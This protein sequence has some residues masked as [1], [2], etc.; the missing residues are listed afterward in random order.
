MK[1]IIDISVIRLM[2]IGCFLFIVSGCEREFSDDVDFA[3]FTPN[4]DVFLDNFSPGLDYFPFV[5]AGADPEAFSVVSDETFSGNGA[6]RFD[7]PAFGNGFVGAT[8]NTTV[9]RDLSSFDALTFYAKASKSATIN[10]IGYGL[11]G[12]TANKFRVALSG[13]AVSTR[14]EKYTIP[15]PDSSKLIDQTGLFWLAEGASFE[16][17]EG[18]YILWFDEVKF[19]KLGTV[20]QPRPA[21]FSG[22]DLTQGTFTG[23]IIQA[24]GLTQTFNLESG[25]NQTVEAA[26]SYFN[27]TSSDTD[28]AT[29]N[30]LGEISVIGEGTTTITALLGGVLAQGSL[31]IT[32]SGSLQPSPVPTRPA[33]N[34]KSIFSDA[35]TNDTEINFAP[36]FGGSTTQAEVIVTNGNSVLSYSNN[37]FT[38]IVFNNPVDAS[39]LGF[40]HVDV[41]VQNAGTEVGLQIRDVGANQILE[42]DPNTGFPIVD[43]KD[44][45]FDLTGLTV[46]QWTSFDIPLGGDLASQKNNL[47]ALI[48][49]AGPDFILDNIYFYTE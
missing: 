35:Y 37:N 2:M 3:T 4:G 43:D 36:G 28:V 6:M 9:N 42:T 1:K 15:I 5:G 8:F 47:G 18:G 39:G 23:S 38:G 32:S 20:A 44:F 22:Q 13:L 24:S 19:E 31:E 16:G 21:I 25:V 10:E 46:G 33:A 40:L 45:R 34:V 14:W 49:V 26:P 29:V 41:Y 11:S 48:L 12:E 17:D 7:V 27:F 30:E